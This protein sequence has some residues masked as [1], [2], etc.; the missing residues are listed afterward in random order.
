MRRISAGPRLSL[1]LLGAALACAAG[2][3]SSES[4]H[5]PAAGECTTND[6]AGGGSQSGG[7]GGAG[8]G[9]DAGLDASGDVDVGDGGVELHG[10]VAVTSDSTFVSTTP[11]P[12][13]AEVRA[14]VG[15]ATLSTDTDM[16]AF[17]LAGVAPGVTWFGVSDRAG[18]SSIFP[19]LQIAQVDPASTIKLVGVDAQLFR[20]AYDVVNTVGPQLGT[21]PGLGHAI[22]FFRRASAPL[23]G[24][25]LSGAG[26]AQLVAY[27]AGVTYG[28][29]PARTQ[30]AGT[31]ILFGVPAPVF[32]GA[33]VSVTFTVPG[34]GGA[35]GGAGGSATFAVADGWVTRVYVDVL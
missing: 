25:T 19:T 1:A 11:Y 7:G 5:P 16:G 21:Q 30:A 33:S 22:L 6:C 8:G 35:D 15:A 20:Q 10:T 13:V 3:S 9:T 18:G 34:D 24:V 23:P 2:C 32:P 29:S 12:A 28:T 4:P 17:T 14:V 27:D 31:A 26:G